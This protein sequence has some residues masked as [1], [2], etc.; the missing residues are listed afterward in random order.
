M[1][2]DSGVLSSR[3]KPS[4]QERHHLWRRNKDS[5]EAQ[6]VATSCRVLALTP[7]AADTHESLVDA[8]VLASAL[9]AVLLPRETLILWLLVIDLHLLVADRQ[10]VS[11]PDHTCFY[12][13]IN[14]YF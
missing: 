13:K 11:D 14:T 6:K 12:F 9:R 2:K 3:G 1:N 10:A 4:V 8:V 7:C 5:G